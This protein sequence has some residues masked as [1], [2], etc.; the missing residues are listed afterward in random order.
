MIRILLA[1]DHSVVREGVRRVLALAEDFEVAGEAADGW[2]LLALARTTPADLLITDLGMPGP[3]GIELIKRLREALPRLPILAFT[4]HA[5][6]QLATRVMRAG[7]NG[8]LT[9]DSEP[10]ELIAAVRR[11]ARGQRYVDPGVSGRLL[12]DAQ[13]NEPPHA[14]LSNRELQVLTMLANG[15]TVTAIARELNLS[16]KTVST[17]KSRLMGKLALASSAELVR[18]ALAHGLVN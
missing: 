15:S 4:M 13:G 5:D 3:H 16:V 6:N 7:A 10:G 2:D 17:H 11:I 18:Y 12:L 1:D 14:S 8:Y 9:K